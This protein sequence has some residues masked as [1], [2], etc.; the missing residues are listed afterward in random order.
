[1]CS[2]HF[3]YIITKT[4]NLFSCP[5]THARLTPKTYLHAREQEQMMYVCVATHQLCMAHTWLCTVMSICNGYIL[6]HYNLALTW[7][8]TWW[9]AKCHVVSHP[10]PQCPPHWQQTS[11]VCQSWSWRG[12]ACTQEH[13]WHCFSLPSSS[14]WGLLQAL[15][16]CT[17]V[18]TSPTLLRRHAPILVRPYWLLAYI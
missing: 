14:L 15:S 7:A 12:S 3:F 17:L 6:I 2:V 13:M 18:R 11:P 5:F 4:C 16:F 10:T 9:A 8:W 1:M